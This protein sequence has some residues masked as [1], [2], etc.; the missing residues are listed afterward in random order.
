MKESL[1]HRDVGIFDDLSKSKEPCE[2]YEMEVRMWE[3]AIRF[4]VCKGGIPHYILYQDNDDI[5]SD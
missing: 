4:G 1:N 2:D 3:D 5:E